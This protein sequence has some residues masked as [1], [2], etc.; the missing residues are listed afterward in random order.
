VPNLE[1][2]AAAA[3]N[4][5]PDNLALFF[6]ELYTA[7]VRLRAGRQDVN[8]ADVFR[9]QVLHAIKTAE[10]NART[11]GYTDEDVRLGT[12]AMVAFLD[13]SILNLRKPVFQRLGAQTAAGG[14]VRPPCGG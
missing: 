14:A 13:E 10:Q 4:P 5:W 2:G 7:I 1:E 11:R 6:Q 3:V 8:N 9:N 12:F